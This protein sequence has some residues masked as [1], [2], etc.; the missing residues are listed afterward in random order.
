[1]VRSWRMYVPLSLRGMSMISD[2][3][4]HMHNRD[5]M[6]TLKHLTDN[7]LMAFVAHDTFHIHMIH[8]SLP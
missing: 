2:I 7:R 6:T 1:M 5:L 8:F 4:A 3:N